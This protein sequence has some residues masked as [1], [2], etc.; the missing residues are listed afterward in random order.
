MSAYA[1]SSFL[2]KLYIR[3]QETAMALAAAATASPPFLFTALHRLEL[4]N[5]IRRNVASKK[6]R[7]S[8]A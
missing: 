2:L 8:Q 6:I 1:D 7:K 3:E 5:A 4:S